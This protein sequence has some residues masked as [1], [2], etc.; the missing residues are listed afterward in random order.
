MS[1]ESATGAVTDG[2]VVA[3]AAI[4]IAPPATGDWV[5]VIDGQDM[6]FSAP[7]AQMP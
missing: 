1:G 2:G 4:S 7:G 3:K 5:L 6:P